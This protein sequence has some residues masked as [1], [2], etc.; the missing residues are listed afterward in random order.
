MDTNTVTNTPIFQEKDWGLV[1]VGSYATYNDTY[2]TT[3]DHWVDIRTKKDVRS[4]Q[5][6]VRVHNREAYFD[7]NCLTFYGL[8]REKMAEDF[9]DDFLKSEALKD[10]CLHFDE[11]GTQ[12][13]RWEE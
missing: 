8:N 10:I 1:L 5:I 4:T 11:V 7:V 12:F 6:S 3:T 13:G 2:R 9:I